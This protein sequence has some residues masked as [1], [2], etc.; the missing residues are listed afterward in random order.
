MRCSENTFND[1]EMLPSDAACLDKEAATA[2]AVGE[3]VGDVADMNDEVSD[4]GSGAWVVC[5]GQGKPT[6]NTPP[7]S[8]THRY[9]CESHY[10]GTSFTEHA[11]D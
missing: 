2:A 5:C 10:I 4:S 3:S 11:N 1:R 6:Q 9:R 7:H 8:P